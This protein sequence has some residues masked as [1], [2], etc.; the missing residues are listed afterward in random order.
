MNYFKDFLR[1]AR[2]Q[3]SGLIR[4]AIS[5]LEK[6][7]RIQLVVAL[8]VSISCGAFVATLSRSAQAHRSQWVSHVKVRVT[9]KHVKAGDQ[10]TSHNTQLVDLPEATIA[11]DAIAQLPTRAR[12]RIALAP[13]TPL[14]TS[15]MSLAESRVPIPAGWRGVAMPTDIIAPGLTPGDRVDVVAATSVV[16]T[17]ALVIEVSARNIIT[18]AVPAVDAALV[19]S[20][21]RIGDISL[22]IAQ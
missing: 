12:A 14:S 8:V 18:V 4:F 20:A 22:V 9:T 15:L 21:A 16:S 7:R 19:A 6:H 11:D 13:R 3:L 10:F 2:A 17:N 5:S 1:A